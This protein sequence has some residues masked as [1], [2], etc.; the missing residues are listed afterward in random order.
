MIN[1]DLNRVG[2]YC[3]TSLPLIPDIRSLSIQESAHDL[4]LSLFKIRTRKSEDIG[5]KIVLRGGPNG[6]RN[7]YLKYQYKRLLE[8]I[9]AFLTLNK[10]ETEINEIR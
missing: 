2:K 10:N 8:L 7:R 9:G 3:N 5:S 6:R 1:D 4:F